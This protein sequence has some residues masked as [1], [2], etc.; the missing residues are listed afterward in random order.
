MSDDP[1]QIIQD[2][3]T[4]ERARIAAMSDEEFQNWLDPK[5]AAFTDLMK[6]KSKSNQSKVAK[7][8]STSEEYI[9]HPEHGRVY[10]P[11]PEEVEKARNERDMTG[12]EIA[13][14]ERDTEQYGSPESGERVRDALREEDLVKSDE[15]KEGKRWYQQEDL[16][17]SDYGK[18]VQSVGDYMGYIPTP[19]TKA[20]GSA[21]YVTGATM[22]GDPVEAAGG[23]L[24][25]GVGRLASR[26]ASEF[27]K[28]RRSL[29]ALKD[30]AVKNVSDIGSSEAAEKTGEALS[31]K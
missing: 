31:D 16:G 8:K 29:S 19:P 5:V 24:G 27:M 14:Q 17:V 30:A 6:S 1:A 25:A 12:E 22:Q 9:D 20:V 21:M 11:S 2:L 10:A 18:S 23:V 3:R 26:A 15:D 28:R 4:S 7:S 13:Q